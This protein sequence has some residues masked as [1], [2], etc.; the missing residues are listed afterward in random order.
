MD[1]VPLSIIAVGVREVVLQRA[2]LTAG[3]EKAV[4]PV[5]YDRVSLEG[6]PVSAV[7]VHPVVVVGDLVI[8]YQT[9]ARRV[10]VYAV[11]L[12]GI[13]DAETGQG[14]PVHHEGD[15]GRP[16]IGRLDD[17]VRRIAGGGPNPYRFRHL[18]VL[19]IGPRRNQHRVSVHGNINPSL[20]RGLVTRNADG[21]RK[22]RR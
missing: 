2:P 21:F 6:V 20:Y 10:D 8:G 19:H 17:R 14:A 5:G 1:A 22:T 18:Q 13:P 9:F 12:Q 11:R 4:D 3:K 16:G 7:G 15:H